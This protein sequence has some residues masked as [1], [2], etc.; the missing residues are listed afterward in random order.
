[1]I[2][3]M[4]A[5]PFIDETDSGLD[6]KDTKQLLR[7]VIAYHDL[8]S[9][10]RAMRMMT[11][12][13]KGLGDQIEFQPAPWSFDLLADVDWGEAADRDAAW[14]DILITSMISPNPLPIS[15]RRWAEFAISRKRGSA[16][17]VV[18]LFG[19]EEKP[20][21]AGSSR[22]EAI[23]AAAQRAGLDFFAPAPRQELDE[24][25][26]RVHQRAEMVRPLFNDILPHHSVPRREQHCKPS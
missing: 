18:A 25:I 5:Q 15:V 26:T 9:G 12:L 10:K 1:M 7:V 4:Q 13:G 14:A 19:S 3:L 2:K 22:L 24:A 8:A 20:D 11:D 16:A 6:S 23:Q 21:G 17:A